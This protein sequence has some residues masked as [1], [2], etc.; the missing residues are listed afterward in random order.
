MRRTWKLRLALIFLAAATGV[1]R[2][3]PTGGAGDKLDERIDMALK[4]AAPA[5]LFGTFAKLFGP[6][7]VAVVDPAV[8]GPVTIELHNVRA[9]T[10]LDAVCESIGCRWSVAAATP[11]TPAKLFVV[12]LP[13]R[14]R[15]EGAQKKIPIREPIDFKV[16]QADGRDVLRTFGE[17]LN[18][19]VTV[20]PGVAGQVTL[21]LE[22]LPVD[23]TLDAVCKSLGCEWSFTEGANGRKAVLRVWPKKK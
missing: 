4:N 9:R 14:E 16:T 19:D 7:A 5:D 1:A 2:A 6:N 21:V 11:T 3:E 13:A 12:P 17:I 18:A 22:N 15:G 20:E 10:L 23:Q 8:R